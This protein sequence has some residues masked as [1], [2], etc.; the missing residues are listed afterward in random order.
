MTDKEKHIAEM[1]RRACAA[2]EFEYNGSC[3]LHRLPGQCHNATAVAEA[4][5]NAEYR[6]QS[7]WISVDERLPEM[8]EDVLCLCGRSVEIDFMCSDDTWC[9]VHNKPITHWMPLPEPPK[10]KCGESDA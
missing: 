2:C 7:E 5:Y 10:M 6:K 9:G 4:F 3:D 1:P 8:H